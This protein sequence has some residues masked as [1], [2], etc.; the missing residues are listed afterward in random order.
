MLPSTEIFSKRRKIFSIW[1]GTGVAFEHPFG[2]LYVVGSVWTPCR[3]SRALPHRRPRMRRPSYAA[4]RP[5]TAPAP[6]PGHVPTVRR[7]NGGRLDARNGRRS[8]PDCPTK[9]R[10]PVD[11][12]WRMVG[13][14]WRRPPNR[15]TVGGYTQWNDDKSERCGVGRIS[16]FFSK[17]ST[18]NGLKQNN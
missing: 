5:R 17:H 7:E 18:R 9:R 2:R 6:S 10:D 12:I 11:A 3:T 13:R 4:D 8:R 15:Q 16:I 1:R 14:L